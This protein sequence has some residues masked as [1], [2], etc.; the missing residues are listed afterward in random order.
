[1]RWWPVD[2]L[3]AEVP[4]Q[5]VPRLDG[6]LTQLRKPS[7]SRGIC[8]RRAV[9][10]VAVDSNGTPSGTNTDT[11]GGC[12]SAATVTRAVTPWACRGR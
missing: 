7:L 12:H 6:L 3:P 11:S 8:Y 1:M 5:L 4:P 2:A 9:R 10:L